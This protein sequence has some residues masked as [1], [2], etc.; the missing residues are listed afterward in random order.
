MCRRRHRVENRVGEVQARGGGVGA[1]RGGETMSQMWSLALEIP[2]VSE[3]NRFCSCS[4]QVHSTNREVHSEY[5][6]YA[7]IYTKNVRVMA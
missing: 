6:F 2:R 5:A 7:N 1:G 4:L 3:C